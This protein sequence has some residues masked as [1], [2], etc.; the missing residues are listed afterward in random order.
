MEIEKY[1]ELATRALGFNNNERIEERDVLGIAEV[2]L[3]ELIKEM[4]SNGGG[5]T[6][7]YYHRFTST[8]EFDTQMKLP[9]IYKPCDILN[10]PKHQSYRY[11]GTG[12]IENSFIPMT[13]GEI[14][15]YSRLEAGQAGGRT[16]FA[17]LGD[18]IYFRYMQEPKPC[19]IVT[20]IVPSLLWLYDNRDNV[21]F[22]GTT[23]VEGVL[24]DQVLQKLQLRK[25][26]PVDNYNN[27]SPDN[28]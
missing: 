10:L 27:N 14:A 17:P 19:E 15:T 20:M 7:E 23:D 13:W 3:G 24:F 5:L 25:Q 6:A 2:V 26:M 1:A 18:K 28:K 22:V 11:V 8:L 4:L 9:F 21:N 16:V 12:D